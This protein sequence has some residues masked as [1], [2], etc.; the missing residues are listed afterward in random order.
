MVKTKGFDGNKK[1]KGKKYHIVVDTTGFPLVVK[2]H[3]A[4]LSDV[5]QAFAIMNTLFL[6]FATIKIIVSVN[7]SVLLYQ[8]FFVYLYLAIL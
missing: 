7:N 1:V 3:D 8:S 4:N 6:C 2:V 5:K